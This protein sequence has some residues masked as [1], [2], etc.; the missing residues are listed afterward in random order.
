M[1]EHEQRQLGQREA[2]RHA[3]VLEILLAA[4]LAATFTFGGWVAIKVTDNSAR[5]AVIEHRLDR[6][7]KRLDRIEAALNILVA[8]K[9]AEDGLADEAEAASTAE[10]A[11]TAESKQSKLSTGQGERSAGP[12]QVA[13]R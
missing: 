1:T 12:G 9:K 5:V 3:R 4:Y 13:T 8:R 7:E 2:I 6:I 10:S 11:G